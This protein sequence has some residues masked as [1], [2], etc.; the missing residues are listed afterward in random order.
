MK[1]RCIVLFN[2]KSQ[3]SNVR[4]HAL[5]NFCSGKLAH[6]GLHIIG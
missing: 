5:A 4:G 1:T 6:A 2:G 3:F